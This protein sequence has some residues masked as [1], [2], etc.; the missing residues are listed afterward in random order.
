VFKKFEKVPGETAD[1]RFQRF[2][3]HQ[4]EAAKYGH[5][6]E[7]DRKNAAKA[8]KTNFSDLF[9]NDTPSNNQQ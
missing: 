7:R 3:K 5:A 1:E 2:I 6:L 4:S 9:T 8:A